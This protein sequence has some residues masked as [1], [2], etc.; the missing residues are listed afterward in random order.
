MEFITADHLEK[1]E[2]ILQK[3]DS[4]YEACK[5]LEKQIK[6]ENDKIVAANIALH[7]DVMRNKL[8]RVNV[9]V[10]DSVFEIFDHYGSVLNVV[11]N[12][13]CYKNCKFYLVEV[14]VSTVFQDKLADQKWILNVKIRCSNRIVSQCLNLKNE[15]FTYPL[16]A[17][18]PVVS[19]ERNCRVE[20]TLALPS[21]HFW[22]IIH[23][24]DV[25]LDISYNFKI[26]NQ[27]I[28]N[29]RSETIDLINIFKCYCKDSNV[30]NFV[31]SQDIREAT[32]LYN[33]TVT[34]FLKFLIWNSYHRVDP[35]MFATL[36][37]SKMLNFE[38]KTDNS[39]LNRI[40]I[41]FNPDENV[42][43]IK[44]TVNLMYE[45]KKYFIRNTNEKQISLNRKASNEFGV[46]IAF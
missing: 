24:E 26:N 34:D 11:E 36:E 46:C 31:N 7:K 6:N 1:Y 5:Q 28:S 4:E 44:T 45:I 12:L 29:S 10:F 18:L 37:K 42:L 25:N 27:N 23:L 38:I 30:K 19:S 15:A 16:I 21:K 32:F 2:A 22:T 35:E 14:Y 33:N 40:L 17:I 8:F 39:D 13:I 41:Y 20:T 3:L 9:R 43:K